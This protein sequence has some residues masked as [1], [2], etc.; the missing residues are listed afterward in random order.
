MNSKLTNELKCLVFNMAIHNNEE[1]YKQVF[2]LLFNPLFRFS[3][4]MIRSREQAEEVASDVIFR[5]WQNRINLLQVENIKVYVF[6]IARNL[7]LNSIKRNSRTKL[8]S[9]EEIRDAVNYGMP[10]P[11]QI[12]INQEKSELLEKAIQSLPTRCNLVFKLI[13]E[14]GLTYKE[15][16]EIL[17]IS[18]KTVDAHLVTAMN[19]LTDALK[20]KDFRF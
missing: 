9:I 11:E 17:N 18:V 5:L 7:S 1:A 10:D 8:I 15:V 13:K 19:K 2:Y 6:T 4:S 14:E 20:L 3:Y 12:L 16:A